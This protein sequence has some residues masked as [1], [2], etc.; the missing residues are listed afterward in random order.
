M[1]KKY[2]T[3]VF[4]YDESAEVPRAITEAFKSD[5]MMYGDVKVT[6][7]SLEDEITRCEQ[8]EEQLEA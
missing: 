8:L 3:A 5:S 2:L 7:I 1:A 6:A 4:E